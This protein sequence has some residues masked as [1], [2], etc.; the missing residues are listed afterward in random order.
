M[1]KSVYS[2]SMISIRLVTIC[3]SVCLNVILWNIEEHPFRTCIV[4]SILVEQCLHE[5]SLE[6]G[7]DFKGRICRGDL[8][9]KLSINESIDI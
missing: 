1:N 8:P 3:L 2:T 4:F 5:I 7:N 9:I 6:P